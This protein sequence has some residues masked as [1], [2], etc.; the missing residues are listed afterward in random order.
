MQSNPKIAHKTVEMTTNKSKVSNKSEPKPEGGSLYQTLDKKCDYSLK[1]SITYLFSAATP[2]MSI[3]FTNLSS[4]LSL[5]LLA[6]PLAMSI[7]LSLDDRLPDWET[8]KVHVSV[9][10][11]T[12]LLGYIGS[13]LYSGSHTIF[14]TFTGSQYAMM[15]DAMNRLGTK[16]FP[17]MGISGFMFNLPL[18]LSHTC[19]KALDYF[20]SHLLEGLRVG[21]CL[22]L[23]VPEVYFLLRV[24][25]RVKEVNILKFIGSVYEH[26]SEIQYL[27]CITA[28]ILSLSVLALHKWKSKVPWFFLI[29]IIGSIYGMVQESHTHIDGGK[30]PH[31]WPVFPLLKHNYRMSS[32]FSS[33]FETFM[34]LKNCADALTVFKSF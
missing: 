3:I 18:A 30:K 20:P 10:I 27:E 21:T 32:S 14:R 24:P 19:R 4:A 15:S 9:G 2:T 6:L 23:I 11:L 26:S 16:C 5:S 12:L 29:G 31:S 17:G 25:D 33:I 13:F 7:V 1:S 34:P 22:Y 8:H 28:I